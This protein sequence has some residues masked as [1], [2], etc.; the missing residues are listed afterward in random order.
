[1]RA[2]KAIPL[3]QLVKESI[4]TR[5]AE[6]EW[7]PGTFLPP[8]NDLAKE[9]KVSHGTLRRA[10]DELTREL[11]LTRYQGKGTAVSILDSD[12]ALFKF[13]KIRREDG[14]RPLPTSK[15]IS[16]TSGEGKQEGATA[17]E[18]KALGIEEE[19]PV[20][21][22]HR[23][24]IIDSL[25]LFNEYITLPLSLFPGINKESVDSIPNTLYDYYQQKYKV[26]I[27]SAK[28]WLSAVTATPD[29]V[30]RIVVEANSPVLRME[31]ICYDIKGNPV[32]YR[33]THM[34]TEGYYYH[35]QLAG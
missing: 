29:D 13:F 26:T 22:I 18:A 16:L 17:K 23:I 21:R 35:S 24:R 32:E 4:L 1:M 33:I 19:A 27:S 25:P 9:Y 6:E 14:G 12:Q 10:L 8:E 3:Y 2:L 28:E 20:S 30:K 31:R 34:V 5:I 11:R 15:N 7:P